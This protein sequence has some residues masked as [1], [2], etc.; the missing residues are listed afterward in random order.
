MTDHNVQDAHEF[1][2]YLLNQCSELLEKDQVD[3][4]RSLEKR[5]S[6]P[7]PP[8]WIQELFQARFPEDIERAACRQDSSIPAAA[9]RDEPAQIQLADGC[10]GL[11]M[12]FGTGLQQLVHVRRP[13][14]T[15][16]S[17]LT[18][19]CTRWSALNPPP[20]D[21]GMHHLQ[22]YYT[23]IG[24]K[25]CLAQGKLVNETR[26]LQC[27]TTTSRQEAFYELSL[28]IEQNSSL[29]TCLRNFRYCRPASCATGRHS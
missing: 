17:G 27:E 16:S 25:G 21:V 2:N 24:L 18:D 26:C 20:A 1:L 4:L 11:F 8:T 5:P 13:S 23:V 3:A 7:L 6:E 14:P 19:S 12:R 15:P 10:V 22:E 28:D 29:S 9:R